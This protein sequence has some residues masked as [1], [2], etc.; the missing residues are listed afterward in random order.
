[1]KLGTITGY[2]QMF[3]YQEIKIFNS[4]NHLSF[5]KFLIIFTLLILIS[6]KLKED[7]AVETAI[8][9]LT[10][11]NKVDNKRVLH[12]ISR[13]IEQIE[14]AKIT[15][16]LAVHGIDWSFNPFLKLPNPINR[17]AFFSKN[18]DFVDGLWFICLLIR[19]YAFFNLLK[20]L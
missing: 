10:H 2:Y 19:E 6:E 17:S 20:V 1:M 12:Q 3:N 9:V 11:W 7:I 4:Y 14:L 8:R 13:E 15:D 5:I 18:F 16:A